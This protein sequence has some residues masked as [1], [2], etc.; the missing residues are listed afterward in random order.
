MSPAAY[1][2]RAAGNVL[3]PL[4]PGPDISMSPPPAAGAFRSSGL[5]GGGFQN[6]IAQSP[7]TSPGGRPLVMGSDVSGLQISLDGARTWAP[8][9]AGL[10]THVA[11]VEWDPVTPGKLFAL[12]GNG[13]AGTLGRSLDYGATWVRQAAAVSADGNGV[14]LIGGVEH[15][16]PTGRLI[17]LDSAAAHMWVGTLAGVRLSTDEGA[18]FTGP[19]AL[20]A[21][22]L[23]SMAWDP[24]S[25]DTLYVAVHNGGSAPG[26]DTTRN[27]V[28]QITD[29]RTT[30]AAASKVGVWPAGRGAEELWVDDNAGVSTLWAVAHDAG[31]FSFS[32]G[33]WTSRNTNL[34][35]TG[36]AYC[37]IDGHRTAAGLTLVVSGASP[38][39]SR[40]VYRSA[41]SG[42]TWVCISTGA[43]VVV[44]PNDYGST[45]PAW[46]SQLSYQNWANATFAIASAVISN[47][48]PN[49]ILMSGRGGCRVLELAGGTWTAYPSTAGLMVTVNMFVAVHP[50]LPGR[51][52]VGSMDYTMN[53]TADGGVS[54]TAGTMN[55][56]GAQ[57][58]GDAGA[59]DL[60]GPA[61]QAGVVGASLRG[62]P[63]TGPGNGVYLCPDPH[64]A[65]PV[66]TKQPFPAGSSADGLDVS[67]VTVGRSGPGGQQVLLASVTNSGVWRKQAAGAWTAISDFGVNVVGRNSG[68]FVQHPDTATVYFHGWNGLWRSDASGQDATWTQIA[69]ATNTYAVLDSIRLDPLDPAVL[70][71]SRGA[72]GVVRISNASTAGSVAAA[73]T[74]VLVA[75]NA[76]PIAVSPGGSLYVAMRAGPLLQV[77][78]P[79]A[80]VPAAGVDVSNAFWQENST[81]I[82]SMA[83]TVDNVLLTADN[84]KGC[85]AG[86]VT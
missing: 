60:V 18:T 45:S 54:F 79:R 55:G 73:S 61:P 12:A 32:G 43:G 66:W 25:P 70:Y 51:A 74:T 13:G 22:H 39:S 69:T 37:A 80:A 24:N 77:A 36:M 35:L 5:D 83:I 63:T 6:V 81:N 7:F 40:L 26:G 57:S 48:D 16:R 49:V 46:I 2:Y 29:A 84:G 20:A 86:T 33:T 34:D 21:D 27:G 4:L 64:A 82:R 72:S 10:D 30:M 78:D 68:F 19:A 9:G 1:I 50:V 59:Y 23:R 17:V 38:R 44:S 58:T 53:A 47:D 71:V 8:H 28:W 11:A 76:G 67:A 75:G 52:M 62:S 3:H 14:Y 31:V 41:D 42:A 56:S 65:S 15:P 85:M